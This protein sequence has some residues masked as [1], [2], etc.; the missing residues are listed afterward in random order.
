MSLERADDINRFFEY[1]QINFR[2]FPNFFEPD[3]AGRKK[4]AARG[5]LIK[6]ENFMPMET[7]FACLWK[8]VSLY[9]RK[10]VLLRYKD[11]KTQEAVQMICA[12]S[13]VFVK[14][15]LRE[16]FLNALDLGKGTFWFKPQETEAVHY[17]NGKRSVGK[18]Q[19]EGGKVLKGASRT[20]GNFVKPVEKRVEIW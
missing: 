13:C 20:T 18:K 10:Q 19:G 8:R 15:S 1:R 2:N 17:C 14:M 4:F 7:R 3:T 9:E 11:T 5:M 12:A 16:I 6:T